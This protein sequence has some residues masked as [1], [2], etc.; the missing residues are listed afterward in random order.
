MSAPAFFTSKND[1]PHIPPHAFRHT[2][3]S[4]MIAHGVDIVTA[5]EKLCPAGPI[6]TANT[7]AHQIAGP[8]TTA[9]THAHQIA[10]PVTTANTYAHQ[11][12]GPVTT[13]NTYAH[14]IAGA[15]A[16]AKAQNVRASV[17]HF[18]K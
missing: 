5:A 9:N 13:A 14:Q 2:A 15:K 10:G 17:F 1:P 6:T 4:N 18:E 7:H 8:I 11:I 3:A 16:K 12:A